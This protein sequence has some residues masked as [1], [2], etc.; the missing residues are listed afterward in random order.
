MYV[1]SLRY[2]IRRHSRSG[3]E[4]A[5]TSYLD[6]RVRGRLSDREDQAEQ[7]PYTAL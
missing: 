5:L 3:L 1:D 4:R 6:T 7:H 2:V